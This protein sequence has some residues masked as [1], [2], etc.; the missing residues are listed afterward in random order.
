MPGKR[1]L[2]LPPVWLFPPL[3][4]PFLLLLAIH[5]PNNSDS[6]SISLQLSNLP[7]ERNDST[8]KT[9][10]FQLVNRAFLKR[11]CYFRFVLGLWMR[12]RQQTAKEARKEG[13][14]SH[15]GSWGDLPID[16]LPSSPS[17]IRLSYSAAASSCPPKKRERPD[18]F[19]APKKDTWLCFFPCSVCKERGVF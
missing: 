10:T 17:P 13:T 14:P 11:C 18:T 2:Y 15:T 9:R 5:I 8:G 4:L 19:R 16:S 7:V 6:L 1:N 3:P 12:M